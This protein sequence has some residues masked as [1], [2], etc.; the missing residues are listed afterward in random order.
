MNE[1]DLPQILVELG[2]P[3]EEVAQAQ[4]DGTLELLGLEKFVLAEEHNL[5]VVEVAALSG[6]S[7]EQVRAYW[8][9]LGFAD[10]RPGEKLFGRLD[11]ELLGSLVSFIDEDLLEP[12]LALQMA[13]VVGSA[14]T[15][16]ANAQ[17]ESI[18]LGWGVGSRALGADG[19]LQRIPV[20]TARRTLE[21]VTL[22]PKVM[23]FVWRRQLAAA[24]RR[25]I[26]RAEAEGA[27]GVLVGFADL[28]GFT[29]RTQQLSDEDLAHVVGR[30]EAVSFDLVSAHGG[31]VVKM[32]GDEVMFMHE[33]LRE[34]AEL[35]LE[36]AARFRED[37]ELSDVRVGLAAGP[38]LERDGDVYGH[39]VN[40]ANRLVTFAYPGSV[41]VSEEVAAAVQDDPRFILRSL[42]SHELKDMGPTSMYVLRSVDGHAAPRP[43]WLRP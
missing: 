12:D 26:M 41:M 5:D 38:V 22:L 3:P 25:R 6:V 36:M 7:V 18:R 20:L 13:R 2:V 42:G 39:V 24:A 17:V 9:A 10:P 27:E 37:P 32:I 40:L 1:I 28:V 19:E 16:I 21:M 14:M 43:A 35:G 34:G 31:R 11:V 33:D 23:E 29:A 30:F 4:A 15:K 8:R